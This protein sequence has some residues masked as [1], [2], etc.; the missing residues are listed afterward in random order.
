MMGWLVGNRPGGHGLGDKP[1]RTLKAASFGLAVAVLLAGCAGD[2]MEFN[3]KIFDALGVS[4]VGGETVDPIAER[5][6]GIVL[7]P[8]QAALPVPGS[9]TEVAAAI[10]QQLP[11]D[12]KLLAARQAEEERLAEEK[13]CKEEAS[14]SNNSKDY[15]SSCGGL[16]KALF[17]TNATLKADKK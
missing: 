1:M 16:I 9:G 2:G 5:R 6:N 10:E 8:R 3:G 17:G 14:K 15:G 13:R 4:S 12:P 7:P 11:N